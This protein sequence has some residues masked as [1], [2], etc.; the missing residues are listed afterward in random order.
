MGKSNL[1]S[2]HGPILEPEAAA[3]LLMPSQPSPSD[4]QICALGQP[5]NSGS[6]GSIPGLIHPLLSGVM[7]T[8]PTLQNKWHG[9]WRPFANQWERRMDMMKCLNKG[10]LPPDQMILE[11]LKQCLPE[12]DQKLL[13]QRREANRRLTYQEFY[14]EL[15]SLYERDDCRQN[16]LAWE[17]VKLSQGELTLE[18]WE[19]FQRSFQLQRNRVEDWTPQEE[20]RLIVSNLSQKWRE[21]VMKAEAKKQKNSWLVRMKN[22]PSKPVQTLQQQIEAVVGDRLDSV[23]LTPNGG[24]IIECGSADTQ[25]KV[26]NL[27]G[28]HW[29]GKVMQV[30]RME[31]IL[32]GDEIFALITRKLEIHE[33]VKSYEGVQPVTINMVQEKVPY[34]PPH[35]RRDGGRTKRPRSPPS[36]QPAPHGNKNSWHGKDAGKKWTNFG[37]WEKSK[38]GS[39]SGNGQGSGTWKDKGKEKQK[40]PWC[41]PCAQV[42]ADAYHAYNSCPRWNFR[43]QY[44]HYEEAQETRG[45]P[46]TPRG[47]VAQSSPGNPRSRGVR[48]PWEQVLQTP[49]SLLLPHMGTKRATRCTFVS[50]PPFMWWSPPKGNSEGMHHSQGST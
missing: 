27:D 5:A 22:L 18:K 36:P 44:A 9:G 29:D 39:T 40:A 2:S 8:R 17:R 41:F 20:H 15:K 3:F 26:L 38:Q 25:K 32:T 47:D 46:S 42:G 10:G 34:T 21:K 1:E 28:W 31:P 16:R 7:T 14:D 13:D 50:T 37:T 24:V 19:D 45:K 33:K 6:V 23:S 35:Q 49:D 48:T 43:E 30:T 4:V 12:A 11:D